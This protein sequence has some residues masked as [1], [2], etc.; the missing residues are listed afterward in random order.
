[1]WSD[2]ECIYVGK[3]NKLRERIKSHF[4][5]RRGADQF[6]LYIFDSYIKQSLDGRGASITK[7]LNSIT[8]EWARKNLTVNYTECKNSTY[9]EKIYRKSMQPTLNPL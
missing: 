9:Q 5:G 2:D 6:C 8:K 7:Q 3:S 1:M 4:N